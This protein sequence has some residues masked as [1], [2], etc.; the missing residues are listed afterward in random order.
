MQSGCNEQDEREHQHRAK[1][2]RKADEDLG[3]AQGESNHRHRDFQSRNH[4]QR[5]ITVIFTNA[6]NKLLPTIRGRLRARMS[7]GNQTI[8]RP[9]RVPAVRKLGGFRGKPLGSRHAKGT[10]GRAHPQYRA[11]GHRKA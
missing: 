2:I 4:E 7:A 10:D 3:G 11:T 5:R 8:L 1:P 9:Q 6:R